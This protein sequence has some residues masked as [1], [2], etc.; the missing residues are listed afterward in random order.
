MLKIG[1]SGTYATLYLS[2]QGRQQNIR[3]D[4]AIS[5]FLNDYLVVR[6]WDYR[7]RRLKIINK[8]YIKNSIGVRIPIGFLNLIL[9]LFKVKGIEYTLNKEAEISPRKLKIKPA[10]GWTPKEKQLKPLA[11]LSDTSKS[12]RALSLG[13]GVGKTFT[14]IRA[15][16]NIGY[17]TMVVF[18][19]L[20]DNWYKN[21]IKQTTIDPENVYV[22]K[23]FKSVALLWELMDEGYK[24]DFLVCTITTL[25]MFMKRSGN[26]GALDYTYSQWLN[27]VGVGTKIVDECHE[28]IS[29]VVSLDLLSPI[30]NNIYLSATYDASNQK[31][32]EVFDQIFND[33]IVFYGT[34]GVRHTE[35]EV[36]SYDLRIDEKKCFARG[37]YNHFKY[38]TQLLLDK[39]Y[40][41]WEDNVL[42][43]IINGRFLKTRRP[44]H[45]ALIFAGKTDMCSTIVESLTKKFPDIKIGRYCSAS[46]DSE[47]DVLLNPDID[48]VV[49]TYRSAGKGKDIENLY[50]V[51][52]T[53]SYKS[54]VMAKQERGRLRPLKGHRTIFCDLYNRYLDRQCSH[55]Y[56]RKKHWKSEG[57][58]LKELQ[59]G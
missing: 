27:K 37:N 40:G 22:I 48:I 21:V 28:Q 24:P 3:I 18:S 17:V 51:L 57:I 45:R 2:A 11:F 1:V 33:G 10:K 44:H 52:N 42:F 6:E 8:Y 53:E 56:Q 58:S 20:M 23:G 35:I 29:R 14:A 38:E 59:I 47:Q 9:K 50:Y 4:N 13:T 34:R 49:T 25:D 36:Y 19:G 31:I 15:A 7:Y 55:V 46:G 32:K 54:G 30:P 16:L 5:S 41:W 12:Q 26:Y 39:N 43:P